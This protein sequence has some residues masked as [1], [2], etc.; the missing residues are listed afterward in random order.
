MLRASQSGTDASSSFN[1]DTQPRGR[2]DWTEKKDPLQTRKSHTRFF[3]TS[4]NAR[5]KTRA[6]AAVRGHWSV[7]NR[8]DRQRKNMRI[9]GTDPFPGLCGVTATL[10]PRRLYRSG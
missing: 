8:P 10:R 3:L 7:E 4:L 9:F 1:N 2:R 5:E 6:T